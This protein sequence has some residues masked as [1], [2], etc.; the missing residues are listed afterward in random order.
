MPLRPRVAAVRGRTAM[1]T[2][3][4]FICGAVFCVALS[5]PAVQGQA[6]PA[7]DVKYEFASP[8]A[9]GQADA[10]A[11]AVSLLR[12][13]VEKLASRIQHSDALL[14]A[15]LAEANATVDEL[16]RLTHG[17]AGPALLSFERTNAGP[18]FPPGVAEVV[19]GLRSSAE[20][21]GAHLE[22]A[23]A[24]HG[25]KQSALQDVTSRLKDEDEAARLSDIAYVL[26][27][28]QVRKAEYV[29]GCARDLRGC[30]LGWSSQGSAC[31]PPPEY[32]GLCGTVEVAAFPLT[33]KEDFAW[34][35]GASW[36]C[37]PCTTS[38][39]DCPIGW[40]DKAG[41]CVAPQEYD[42]VCSP[43]MD[44]SSFSTRRKAE[45]SATCSARW[46]C[47]A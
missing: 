28:A 37:H 17:V 6:F 12:A 20:L 47:S 35:C 32:G 2:K 26:A 29:G 21:D 5:L 25:L 31:A 18:S 8:A 46:P 1:V 16:V 10:G 13:R 39:E 4:S 38:F 44:F 34:K 42:G 23:S 7:I 22:D 40:S 36:P 15:F 3:G 11:R 45:W 41:L 33:A 9:F 14:G 30:P 27:R 43:A 19:D 24:L